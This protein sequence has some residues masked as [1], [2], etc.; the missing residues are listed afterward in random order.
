MKLRQVTQGSKITYNE[1][2]C[3]VLMDEFLLF[4]CLLTEKGHYFHQTSSAKLFNIS[5]KYEEITKAH[6]SSLFQRKQGEVQKKYNKLMLIDLI[7]L[8]ISI[9]TSQ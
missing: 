6:S 9:I 2:Y 5:T 7:S 8:K 1:T 3:Q 4:L